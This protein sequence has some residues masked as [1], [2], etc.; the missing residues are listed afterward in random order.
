MLRHETI[1]LFQKGHEWKKK[2]L[3]DLRRAVG[4]QAD[5]R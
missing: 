5:A 3:A 1:G 2:L 4:V